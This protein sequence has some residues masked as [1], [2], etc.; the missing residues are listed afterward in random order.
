MVVQKKVPVCATYYGRAIIHHYPIAQPC[1]EYAQYELWPFV[2]FLKMFEENGPTVEY[3]LPV[4][5]KCNTICLHTI[6]LMMELISKYQAV[7][8]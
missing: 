2:Q 8:T 4:H 1:C 6:F 7:N 3:L 5:S